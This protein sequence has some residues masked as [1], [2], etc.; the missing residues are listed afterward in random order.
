MKD[1]YYS[2]G[3]PNNKKIC[4]L[5]DLHN[6]E[7]LPV[8]KSIDKN[9][10]DMILYAG[11]IVEKYKT[12][13]FDS[14]LDK[15]PNSVTLLKECARRAPTFF[16]LG[17]HECFITEKDMEVLE[18]YGITVLDNRIVEHE[19]F[20][21]GGLTSRRV[22]GYR[23]YK[24]NYKDSPNFSQDEFLRIRK[25]LYKEFQ[26]DFSWLEP[27][28]ESD[29]YKI[30]LCHHPEYWAMQKPYLKDMP[31]DLVVAGHAHGGQFRI[32]D[33]VHKRW[34]GVLSPDQGFFPQYSEGMHVNNNNHLIVTRGLA[35]SVAPIPR[36][37]NEK[38]VVYI[39]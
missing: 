4:L 6:Q 33:I 34:Q 29:K 23:Y 17:N 19:E 3:I 1:T 31:I 36:F 2:I 28:E 10:P 30:L 21:I 22:M 37:M 15:S 24:E 27:F 16:S 20:L 8:L 14:I 18:S 26:T 12:E 39:I 25:R 11:D 32:Y 7:Y 38:E 5:A 35:N 13:G 9:K